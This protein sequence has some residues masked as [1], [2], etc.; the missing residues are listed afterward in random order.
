MMAAIST[1]QQV[2]GSAKDDQ[3]RKTVQASR[4]LCP[5]PQ[6]RADRVSCAARRQGRTVRSGVWE[7]AAEGT[8]GS[9]SA[10]TRRGGAVR[11]GGAFGSFVVS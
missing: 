7:R 6:H 9:A 10:P 5:Q 4:E 1:L 2:L 3:E 8:P 11:G